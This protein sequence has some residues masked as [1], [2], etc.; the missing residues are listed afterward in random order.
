MDIIIDQIIY[1]LSACESDVSTQL[2]DVA[3]A[4]INFFRAGMKRC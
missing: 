1:L 2:F 3:H 4:N